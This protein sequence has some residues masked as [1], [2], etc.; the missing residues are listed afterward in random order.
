[1]GKEHRCLVSIVDSSGGMHVCIST[2]G[3]A[4][5]CAIYYTGNI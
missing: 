1:M 2:R 3:D 5:A 4:H